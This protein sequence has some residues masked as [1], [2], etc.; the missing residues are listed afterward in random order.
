[1]SG[2]LLHR[3]LHR[4]HGAAAN[5]R[6]EAQHHARHS[7]VTSFASHVL[8]PS[9][10]RFDHF[11]RTQRAFLVAKLLRLFPQQTPTTA[12]AGP[13]QRGRWNGASEL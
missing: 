11:T 12:D 4:S 1:M 3:R 13:A 5:E 10:D 2:D 8:E 7:V 6:A 9:N